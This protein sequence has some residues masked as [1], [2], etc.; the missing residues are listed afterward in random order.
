MTPE[1]LLNSLSW[2]YATKSFD[3][4]KTIPDATWD[5][6]EQSLVLTPS[7]F[8]LQPWKFLVVTR[9]ETKQALLPHSW[10]QTQVCDCSHLVVLCA[11]TRISKNEVDAFLKSIAETRQTPIEKLSDYASLMHGFIDRMDEN[12]I[13]TWA[14]NQVYIALGQLMASAAVLGI[15]ACPMEGIVPAEYDRVLGLDNSDFHAVVACPM[16]YRSDDDHHARA[17]KVRFPR[18]KIIQSDTRI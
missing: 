14:K 16:G 10:N 8:G 12:A 1:S 11:H 4:A 18:E 15:D 17:A 6:I 9:S 7:S 5:A 3:P 13:E 2:R